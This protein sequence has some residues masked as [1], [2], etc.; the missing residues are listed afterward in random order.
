M[1]SENILNGKTWSG[2]ML[3]NGVVE[4]K[5]LR[6]RATNKPKAETISFHHEFVMSALYNL[7][8]NAINR[9]S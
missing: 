6:S 8:Y 1:S 7:H 3:R 2:P 9:T 5:M 4:Q